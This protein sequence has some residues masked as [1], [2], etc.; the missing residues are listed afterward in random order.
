MIL[1]RLSG[2]PLGPFTSTS[3]TTIRLTRPAKRRIAKPSLR[4][5]GSRSA[6]EIGRFEL[7]RSMIITATNSFLRV[8]DRSARDPV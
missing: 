5:I 1:H 6:S 2:P 4:T 8:E 3:L 7:R